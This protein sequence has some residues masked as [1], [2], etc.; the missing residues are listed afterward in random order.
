MGPLTTQAMGTSAELIA[1]A[2]LLLH[3][4]EVFRNVCSSG[5]IDVMAIKD[6]EIFQFDVKTALTSSPPLT[7][8]QYKAGILPLYVRAGGNCEIGT[9]PL[10]RNYK[11]RN[12]A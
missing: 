2:W 3:G 11:A 8:D 7:I 10:T 9:S 12:R 6:R 4:Y 1:C 5:L